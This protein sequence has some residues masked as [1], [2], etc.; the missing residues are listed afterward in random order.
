H[1]GQ[2]EVVGQLAGGGDEFPLDLDAAGLE[3]EEG[4]QAGHH[5]EATPPFTEPSSRG[6]FGRLQRLQGPVDSE[7]VAGDEARDRAVAL[8][9]G[10]ASTGFTQEDADSVW[11]SRGARW[12]SQ[13]N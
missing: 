12:Q 10:D 13:G 4:G 3:A 1:G 9:V 2:A 7:V 11:Q 8:E 5:S 6:K